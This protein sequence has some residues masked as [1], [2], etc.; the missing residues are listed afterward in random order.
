M[1]TNNVA[2]S[3]REISESGITVV[4][5]FEIG[6]GG[7]AAGGGRSEEGSGKVASLIDIPAAKEP[8]NPCVPAARGAASGSLGPFYAA[9]PALAQLP[10]LIRRLAP[11][12]AARPP[13][14]RI[15]PGDGRCGRR[16]VRQ[17]LDSLPKAAG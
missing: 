12:G 13:A 2:C 11:P 16:S 8:S 5:G 9:R 3:R 1:S 10:A 6:L 14:P 15:V 17:L 7:E 4:D